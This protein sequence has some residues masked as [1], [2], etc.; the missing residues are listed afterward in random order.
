MYKR[1]YNPVEESENAPLGIMPPKVREVLMNNGLFAAAVLKDHG[2]MGITQKDMLQI[3]ECFG[4]HDLSLF[5]S[6][7]HLLMASNLIAQ[8][9]TVEQRERFLPGIASGNLRP[10]ICWRDDT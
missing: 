9:G 2:G 3:A 6:Y 4:A 8:F 7:N 10:C 5:T 1:S